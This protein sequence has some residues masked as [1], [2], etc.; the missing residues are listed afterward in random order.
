[1]PN[2]VVFNWLYQECMPVVV[3]T[4]MYSCRI[5]TT[6]FSCR[7]GVDTPSPLWTEWQTGVKTLPS[8][9]FVC[10]SKYAKCYFYKRTILQIPVRMRNGRSLTACQSL[11]LGEGGLLSGVVHPVF[12]GMGGASFFGGWGCLL[13]GGCLLL[14]DPPVDF[15]TDTGKN[16]TLATTSFLPVNITNG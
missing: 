7:G 8:R 14:A 12:G 15:F 4:E 10:S 6:R 16:I 1:M 2:K 11:L 9:N 5:L 3:A 13:L